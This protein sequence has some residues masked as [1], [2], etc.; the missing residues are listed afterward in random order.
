MKPGAV[1][2]NTSRGPIVDEKALAD[3]LR[4]GRLAAAGLDVFSVEPVSPTTPLLGLD[5]VVLTPHVTCTHRRQ[6][7]AL[8][9][10]SR[11]QLPPAAGT[12]SGWPMW[13]TN[14][15]VIRLGV[16]LPQA[17]GNPKEGDQCRSQSILSIKTW[18]IR[19][20]LWWRG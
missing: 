15:P 7:A 20:D 6:P 11:R 19:C 16:E 13:S 18:P 9:G 10:R 12:A 5:N 4:D 14:P 17:P 2:V 3:A 1:L 8:S